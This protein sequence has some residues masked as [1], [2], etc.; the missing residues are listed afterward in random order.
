M[1]GHRKGKPA[2][3]AR[4]DV[5][6]FSA[7]QETMLNLAALKASGLRFDWLDDLED[8]FGHALIVADPILDC[9]KYH[10]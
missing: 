10:A 1:H 8:W 9:A 6:H 4:D 3:I 7:K 5:V 2:A